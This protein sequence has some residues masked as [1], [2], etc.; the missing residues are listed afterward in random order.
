MRSRA[1]GGTCGASIAA[2]SAET[3]SSLRRRAICVQ[4]AMSTERSSIGGRA[5]ARTTAPASV[6]SAR[7]RSHA[8]TSRIS[9]RWKNA[10]SPTSR[11]GIARSSSATLTAWPSWVISGTSTATRG[12]AG[13][14]SPA[15]RASSRSM[16]TATDWA[17]ERSLAQRHSS[18]SPSG[19]AAGRRRVAQP[20]G[21]VREHRGRGLPDAARGSA[22]CA[23]AP[24]RACP[25]P[26]EAAHPGRARAAVAPQARRRDR[27]RSSPPGA[28]T[29]RWPASPAPG[30]APGRRRAADSQSAARGWAGRGPGQGRRRSGRRRR[31]RPP[32][33]ASAR[34]CSRSGRTRAPA[35]ASGASSA[36]ACAHA[37]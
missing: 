7:R 21:V 37:T 12:R 5:S 1:S 13:L 33:P 9:A 15:S 24:P 36:S 28:P 11:C 26:C 17:W 30:R 10:A 3:M 32:R 25:L 16:S 6:G 31:G 35:R 27:P 18:H 8:S 4:R 20:G 19:A 34:G 14:V 23:R 22:G 29:P 2:A